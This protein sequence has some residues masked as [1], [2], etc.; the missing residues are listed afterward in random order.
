MKRT[1]PFAVALAAALLAGPALA[2]PGHDGSTLAAGIAH[3]LSGLD[4]ML[5]MLAVGLLAARRG[6]SAL[7]AWPAAFVAAMLAG[8]GFGLAAPGALPAEPGVLASLIVL[9]ALAA[10]SMRVATVTGA[11][12]MAAFG[13]C[14]GFAHGGEAPA[15]AGLAFPAG[16]AL[17]TAGLHAAG[18]LAGRFGRDRFVR[19]L[20]GVVAAAG[21]ALAVM[22]A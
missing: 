15:G 22:A 17:A 16:F 3:P 12:L 5:A 7:F 13:L 6:G 20:G 10:S 11:A 14:H 9:G 2:H 21:V 1:L 4:H 19:L 8:Y 18:F